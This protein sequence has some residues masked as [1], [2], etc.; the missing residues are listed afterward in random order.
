MIISWEKIGVIEIIFLFDT[1]NYLL[2]YYVHSLK[3]SKLTCNSNMKNKTGT[4]KDWKK[5]KNYGFIEPTVAGKSVFFHVNDY[6]QKHKLPVKELQVTY[7]LSIDKEG[8]KYAVDVV[9][10][11]GHIKSSKINKQKQFSWIVFLLF[12]SFVGF[13]VYFNKLAIQFLYLYCGMSLIT[14]LVY[15]KDKHAAQN[16]KWRTPESTLHLCSL[17]F[18]WPGA[19]IAQ[20]HLRHKSSKFYFR[21]FYWLTVLVNCIVLSWI[22]TNPGISI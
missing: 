13:L 3:N 1:Y 4:V 17:C 10:K 22:L 2:V 15:F 19:I 8:R 7:K 5:D 18:G 16:G 20:S 6:S 9:P 12:F 11:K 14:F 21:V